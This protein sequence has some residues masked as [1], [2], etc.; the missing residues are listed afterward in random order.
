M[1]ARRWNGSVG[2]DG[3]LYRLAHA[4]VFRAILNKLGFDQLELV[5]SGG[6]PLPRETMALWH[7]YG[8]NVVEIYGQTET[9]GGI[10]AGQRGPFPT[11]GDVG[12]TP[13][14]WNVRLSED[15]EVLVQSDLFSTAI[16][17]MPRPREQ[18][19][20]TTAGCA[21]A[22]SANGWAKPCA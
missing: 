1:R 10:I 5:I 17:A 11:P 6:A 3:A 9:A 20:A 12:T 19:K 8:V 15:G 18:S 21:P 22:T 16:G 2:A 14:G 7:M 13:P 4:L